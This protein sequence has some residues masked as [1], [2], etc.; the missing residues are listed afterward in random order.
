MANIKPEA[1]FRR[2]KEKSRLISNIIIKITTY[3]MPKSPSSSFSSSSYTDDICSD[4]TL[5]NPSVSSPFFCCS[6]SCM[7]LSGGREVGRIS[8]TDGARPELLF[9][10]SRLS[11][12][13]CRICCVI[14]FCLSSS[15]LSSSGPASITRAIYFI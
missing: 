12:Y 3:S 5:C 15:R 4:S 9:K 13:L 10:W 14:L 6:R 8:H 7:L 11:K 1:S 2:Y